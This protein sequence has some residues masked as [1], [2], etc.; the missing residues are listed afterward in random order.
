MK[1]YFY[2]SRQY[3][4]PHAR[5][6]RCYSSGREICSLWNGTNGMCLRM[7][8]CSDSYRGWDSTH[9]SLSYSLYTV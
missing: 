2:F 7:W 9:I 3:S 5:H 1:C 8:N 6:P 4:I